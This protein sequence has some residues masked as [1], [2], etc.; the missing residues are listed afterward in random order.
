MEQ[1]FRSVVYGRIISPILFFLFSVGSMLAQTTKTY[2]PQGT[3]VT[4]DIYSELFTTAE[5]AAKKAYC[6]QTYPRAIYRGEA[7]T[8]YNCHAYTLGV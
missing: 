3:E 8:T 4:L 6:T 2:T 7:T 5:K 1:T